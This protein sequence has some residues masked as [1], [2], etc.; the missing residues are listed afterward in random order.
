MDWLTVLIAVAIVVAIVTVLGLRPKGGRP[1]ERTH[2][3][4]AAR[5]V[6]VIVVAVVAWAVWVR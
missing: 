1:A 6:M 4:T 5:I 3:M 2:L